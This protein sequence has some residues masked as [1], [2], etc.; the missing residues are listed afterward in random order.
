MVRECGNSNICSLEFSV[1]SS[2]T[3]DEWADLIRAF[4]LFHELAALR[5]RGG[6]L[7]GQPRWEDAGGTACAITVM[8][9]D[10]VVR[11]KIDPRKEAP[12]AF[13]LFSSEEGVQVVFVWHHALMDAHGA[14]AL[15]AAFGSAD[16]EALTSDR[17]WTA[18]TISDVF[19]DISNTL[20]MKD[21]L[22]D[23]AREPL[24]KMTVDKSMGQDTG[25]KVVSFTDEETN[26]LM[27]GR[28][29]TGR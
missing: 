17:V 18:T 19:K 7:F 6:F 9:G 26:G 5:L 4:S 22:A 11:R 21:F 23:A 2:R 25:Y 13:D 12:I 16:R 10:V 24:G 8:H 3:A 14:E 27:V 28:A 29:P 20:E 15:L 1:G